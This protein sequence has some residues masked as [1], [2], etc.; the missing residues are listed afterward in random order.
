LVT[1]DENV[2]L[3]AREYSDH[4]HENNPDFPRGEDT[5]SSWGFNYKATEFHGAVGLAQ[6]KK[7]DFILQRQKENKKKIKEAIKDLKGIKFREI[8]DI[9]G[10][11]SD[12][13]V[14]FVES[15]ERASQIAKFLKENGVG[16]KN[17]PDAVNWHFAGTW[18]HIFGSNVSFPQSEDLLRRALAIPIM[19]NMDQDQI[20]KIICL[21]QSA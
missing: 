6:L 10:D 11:A 5:R 14:F 8:P 18:T 15:R 4:G 9:E 21:L 17:L 20:N 12:T 1:D 3:K 13:L 7:L 2:Y 16:T 19:V